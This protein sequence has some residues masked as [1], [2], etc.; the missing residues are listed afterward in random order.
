VPLGQR[1]FVSSGYGKGCGMLELTSDAA[2]HWSVTPVW[3]NRNMRTKFTSA[4]VRGGF[5]YGL[6]EGVLCCVELAD[7]AHCW[8][9]GRYGHGQLLLAGDK[10][11]VQAETGEVA[12]VAAMPDAWRE[13]GRI[14]ALADKTWNYPALAGRLLLVRND[15]EAACYELPVEE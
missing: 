12:L 13:L 14:A 6:D 2:G 9:A 11:V 1:I 5:A 10:L 15:R 7:G 4:V 3:A 8:R